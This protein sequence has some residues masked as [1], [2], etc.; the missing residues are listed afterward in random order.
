M[1]GT[2]DEW[3]DAARRWLRG[4]VGR[5]VLVAAVVLYGLSSLRPYAKDHIGI[6]NEV[7]VRAARTLL[8]GGSP[9]ADKRFLYL[10][11]AVFAA[12]P[13]TFL[14]E[15]VLYYAVPPVTGVLVAA[16]AV[17]AL[18][19]FGVPADSRMAAATAVGLAFFLPFQSLVCLGNW[20]AAS[21]VAF[22][23][24]LLLA[25]RGRWSAAGVV[26]G[27]TIALKPMLVP[28]LLLFVFA[29]RW[30]GLAWAVG[31][32]MAVSLVAAAAMP[33]P[34]LF[35][36]RTLPFLLHGQD[37]YARPYDASWSAVLPRIG[38]PHLPALALAALAGAVVLGCAWV[39]WEGRGGS[40]LRDGR[41]WGDELR[42]VECASL[43]ML[44]AFVVARPSFLN[45]ALVVM[46]SLAASAVV[47]EAAARSVWFWMAL[48]PELGGVPW[49]GLDSAERHA[50]KD[51]VMFGGVA[52]V[53]AVTAWRRR[54]WEKGIV[55]QSNH[56]YSLYNGLESRVADSEVPTPK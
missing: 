12:V 6:D 13:E 7:V 1:T 8:D 39:R 20:T 18:R 21:V 16:G 55:T 34:S 26:V 19:I 53:L 2:A 44:A 23:A 15:R 10:P 27:A 25:G 50:F 24:A 56:G 41:G 52:A 40:D 35:F 54:A 14:S 37:A 29:R 32:P 38:V 46:P 30:R 9:Y 49:P 17:L 3:G 33:S 45:Y 28:V 47:P 11:G 36:T 48:V 42:V 22:P 51:I 43:L 5:P 4:R 31:V